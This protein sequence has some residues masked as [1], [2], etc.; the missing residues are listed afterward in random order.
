MQM[1]DKKLAAL[2]ILDGWGLRDSQHGNAVALAQTPNYDSWVRELDMCV[3]G[4]S[5]EAV[6]LT[7][8][9]MGNSE[10]GHLNL[11]AGFVVHQDITR[12]DRAISEGDFFELPALVQ[13]LERVKE[14]GGKL[15]LFGLLGSGG[16]HSHINHLYALLEL[17]QR[18]DITPI[19]HLIT[20]GRDTPP[21]SGLQFLEELGTFLSERAP[22][23]IATV[24]G[25]YYAMDRDKRWE[26]IEKAYRAYIFGQGETAPTARDAIQKSYANGVS[27]EFILPTLIRDST[28]E[29][30]R[31]ASGDTLIFYNFRAD[32]MRQI[33]QAFAQ[34]DFQGFERLDR[35]QDLHILT[36]TEYEAGLPVNVLFPPVRVQQPIA[37]L[38]S[39]HHK[40][41]FHAAETE[42]YAH[43]TFFFNGGQ[44][45]P[46]EGE[47]RLLVP[48][49]KVATYDLQPEM[50]SEEL[51]EKVIERIRN[52]DDDF[53]LVNFANP[54]MV[55]HT[56][57]LEA[58]ILAV[59]AVDRC[60]GQVVEAVLEKGG[61]AV[62]TAD[63][64][65]AEQMID[66]ET[67][68]PHT[69]HTTNPVPLFVIGSQRYSLKPHGIL[70]DVAPT[71]LDLLDLPTA[72]EMTGE[73]LLARSPAAK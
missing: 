29:D 65:N 61:A 53:I 6:G 71:I 36:M 34:E 27:D 62:V 72:E 31:V 40:K 68:G 42:K 64:G 26:R 58:A 49:P 35:P 63:H 57:S 54:D 22:G 67:G 32:R 28:T 15:H 14:P 56:G 55:G 3:L 7:P 33:V 37:R 41:Q 45:E 12:I 4:A 47:E 2:I 50:S 52:G 39:E 5:G 21:D 10:V 20:D 43:V 18:F 23:V 46:F 38:L 59:E 70:A 44:E 24:S 69:Y 17:A 30:V 11:G 73:S 51:A 9:Q 13:S 16:V 48:S 19:L 25:R 60:A 8:G 66:E 1:I